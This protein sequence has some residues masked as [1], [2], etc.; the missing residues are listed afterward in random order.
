M[1][2]PDNVELLDYQET[3]AV[4]KQK[5]SLFFFILLDTFLQLSQI[6][7][8]DEEID[9]E[10]D[11]FLERGTLSLD[12]LTRTDLQVDDQFYNII[13]LES[14]KDN[15]FK[16]APKKREKL[17]W[18]KT[19][20]L[21]NSFLHDRIIFLKC[22]KSIYSD[23]KISE[24]QNFTEF[25][26]FLTSLYYFF[27]LYVDLNNINLCTECSRIFYNVGRFAYSCSKKCNNRRKVRAFKDRQLRKEQLYTSPRS[28]ELEELDPFNII[29]SRVRG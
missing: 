20:A 27:S 22:P 11:R 25:N 18:F 3:I 8:S 15:N 24:L 5:Y 9:S 28:Y 7:V 10:I 23:S 17:I 21:R 4:L 1:I 16:L 19:S 12:I 26:I 14:L 6:H 2:Y 13:Y 29:P